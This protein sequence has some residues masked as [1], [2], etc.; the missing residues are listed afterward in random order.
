MTRAP[1]VIVSIFVL[2][3]SF[4]AC[5]KA[6]TDHD[7]GSIEQDETESPLPETKPPP[8]LNGTIDAE[9]RDVLNEF[10]GL[11]ERLDRIAA[12]L[13]SANADLCETTQA[14]IGLSVH[15]LNDYPEELRAAARHYLNVGT[16]LSVR[17]VRAGSAAQINGILAGD[18][19]TH[20]N[21]E[22]L[23]EGALFSDPRLGGQIAKAAFHKA[24]DKTKR[25]EPAILKYTRRGQ[26]FHADL[27]VTRHCKLPVTLFFNE[28]INGHYIDG[29]IWMTSGLLREIKD[30]VQIAY[31]MAHEMAHALHEMKSGRKTPERT[32]EIELDAD[33]VGLILLARAGYDPSQLATFWAQQIDLFGADFFDGGQT[34]SDSHPDLKRRADNYALTLSYIRAA[35]GDTDLLKALIVAPQ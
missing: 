1:W 21:G 9:F 17:T 18:R 2:L 25:N 8:Q 12:R 26:S 3:A 35:G 16:D 27:A 30:D 14:D 34:Q 23:I 32:P 4:T 31:I 24:L 22:S 28:N 6:Q 11:N 20:I 13:K 29:E 19:L 10:M 5:H 7:S 33:R 15:T